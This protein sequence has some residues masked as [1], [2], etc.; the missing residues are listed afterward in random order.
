MACEKIPTEVVK[1]SISFFMDGGGFRWRKKAGGA[2]NTLK[3][4]RIAPLVA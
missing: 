4:K 3:R 1:A 2:T